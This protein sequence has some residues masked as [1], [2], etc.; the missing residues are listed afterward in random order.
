MLY[1]SSQKFYFKHV[2]P[3]DIFSFQ[4]EDVL[5]EFEIVGRK[6]QIE[7]ISVP[8]QTLLY[9]IK[10]DEAGDAKNFLRVKNI[11]SA[12]KSIRHKNIHYLLC[13]NK[14][15]LMVWLND[16]VRHRECGRPFAGVWN[17]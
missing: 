2:S 13:A 14:F 10:K 1:S 11:G 9:A 3:R 8:S 16:A 6:F 7:L 5:R 4:E 17:C 12:L 15:Y